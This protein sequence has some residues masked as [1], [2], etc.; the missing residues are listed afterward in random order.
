MCNWTIKDPVCQSKDVV[1]NINSSQGRQCKITGQKRNQKKLRN[2]KSKNGGNKTTD[3]PD[4][5][6]N[7][8]NLNPPPSSPFL[9]GD[10]VPTIEIIVVPVS[11]GETQN[12]EINP[13]E[14]SVYHVMF[15]SN[16]NTTNPSTTE[17]SVL[18]SDKILQQLDSVISGNPLDKVCNHDIDMI[19]I[20][21]EPNARNQV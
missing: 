10:N 15:P 9:Q 19:E 2:T 17:E 20:G 7:S 8:E 6:D 13:K 5:D 11:V 14:H 1:D 18:T 16:T 3:K 4:A 21:D 12:G